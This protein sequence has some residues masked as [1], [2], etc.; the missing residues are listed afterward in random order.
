MWEVSIGPPSPASACSESEGDGQ[1]AEVALDEL[2]QSNEHRAVAHHRTKRRERW[3]HPS[4]TVG[5]QG[6]NG[7]QRGADRP[8]PA[9]DGAQSAHQADG[10]LRIRWVNDVD[11]DGDAAYLLDRRDYPLN[12]GQ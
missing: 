6:R 2:P 11:G 12:V 1:S 4:E 5:E 8:D 3:S 7:H 10:F 9:P